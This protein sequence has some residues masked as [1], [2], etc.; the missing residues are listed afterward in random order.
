MLIKTKCLQ[1]KSVQPLQMEYLILG[2]EIVTWLVKDIE[3][4]TQQTSYLQSN[5]RNSFTNS[6]IK[7]E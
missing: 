3:G 2:V 1:E 6:L 7:V 5:G 4:L